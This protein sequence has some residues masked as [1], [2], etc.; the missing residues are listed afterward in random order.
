MELSVC[1]IGNR[2]PLAD[3]SM[4]GMLIGMALDKTVGDLALRYYATAEAIALQTRQI[5]DE[6]NEKGHQVKSIFMSGG[7][8]QTVPYLFS[9]S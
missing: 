9:L 3:S 1:R 7:C 4:R 8:V 5:I 6:M 2:S